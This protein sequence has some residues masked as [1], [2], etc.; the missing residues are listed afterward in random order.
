MRSLIRTLHVREGS[1]CCVHSRLQLVN[2]V[3]LVAASP[4]LTYTSPCPHGQ[5][6]PC[7]GC[8]SSLLSRWKRNTN[9]VLTNPTSI[10]DWSISLR[11]ILS[12]YY[13]PSFAYTL[14]VELAHSRSHQCSS[15]SNPHPRAIHSSNR[16]PK[17]RCRPRPSTCPSSTSIQRTS[18][19]VAAE[20][21]MRLVSRREEGFL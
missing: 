2:D 9:R 6:F 18:G 20:L 21:R 13:T 16:T 3:L 10:F 17:S 5:S 4:S 15:P 12:Y 1:T 7:A 8:S 19:F 11:F 14:L